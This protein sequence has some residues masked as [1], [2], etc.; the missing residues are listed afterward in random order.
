MQPPRNVLVPGSR[1]GS[2]SVPVGVFW[3]GTDDRT[4]T[5]GLRYKLDQRVRSRISWSAWRELFPA[6][7]ASET[8]RPL[9]VG[10]THSFRVQGR[11]LAGNRSYFTLGSPFS[12]SAIQDS[13]PAVSY[14]GAW[15]AVKDQSAFGRS[16]R[17]TTASGAQ[18][19]VRFRGR[20]VGVVVPI[21]ADLGLAR[22]CLDPGTRR[23]HCAKVDLGP[24]PSSAG[25]RKIVFA[26][27][28]LNPDIDHR[29]LVTQLGG[30]VQLDAIT[31]LR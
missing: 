14:R 22:V 6:R 5:D 12:V 9:A 18:A 28:G 8:I 4:L 27:N 10:S 3:S 13:S 16:V 23:E 11:D 1:L 21:R 19:S 31:L 26:R 30:K 25:A 24:A 17:S 20:S 29:V 2:A 7:S 15:R